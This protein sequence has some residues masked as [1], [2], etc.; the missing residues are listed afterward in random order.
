MPDDNNNTQNPDST[1]VETTPSND[2]FNQAGDNT[3]SSSSPQSNDVEPAPSSAFFANEIEPPTTPTNQPASAA[4]PADQT[5]PAVGA[6]P[7]DNFGTPKKSKK[8]LII[9][10]II[11]A[12]LVLLIGGGALAYVVVRQNPQM[13]LGDAIASLYSVRAVEGVYAYEADDTKVKVTFDTTSNAQSEYGIDVAVDFTSD[14]KTITVKGSGA[15]DKDGNAYFKASGI[16][17]A[18]KTALGEYAESLPPTYQSII[19]KYE[20][21]WV[22]VTAA[23]LEDAGQSSEDAQKCFDQINKKAQDTE[24]KRDFSAAYRENQFITIEDTLENKDGNVRYV[25][26]TDKD[27]AEDFANA[28]KKTDSYKSIEDSCK[29]YLKTGD[30]AVEDSADAENAKVT[31]SIAEW[32]HELKKLEVAASEDD[33]KYNFSADFSHDKGVAVTIPTNTISFSEFSDDLN[34]L[35]GSSLSPSTVEDESRSGASSASIDAPLVARF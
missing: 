31:V 19:R 25:I 21:K 8:K 28:F 4:Q 3:F 17:D 34:S 23:D 22:K 9:G 11:S 27:V 24:F 2:E 7:V 33:S 26:D 12:V 13:I 15:Y 1:P 35:F 30:D 10:S 16:E 32:S 18:V 5:Q 14:G 20:D 29:D 6:Q